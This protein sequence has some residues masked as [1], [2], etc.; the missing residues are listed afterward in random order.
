[1]VLK[2]KNNREADTYENW[3]LS[4]NPE[5]MYEHSIKCNNKS[6]TFVWCDVMKEN[7]F[8]IKFNIY[9]FGVV[10]IPSEL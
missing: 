3:F 8:L 4:F 1:M 10:V 5:N 7:K 6:S 2:D 9:Y